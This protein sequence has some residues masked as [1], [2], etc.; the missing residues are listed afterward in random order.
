MFA[1]FVNSATVVDASSPAGVRSLRAALDKVL[2]ALR[3]LFFRKRTG[4]SPTT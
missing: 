1:V 4:R 3:L 2:A